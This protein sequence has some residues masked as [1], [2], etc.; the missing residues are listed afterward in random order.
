MNYETIA[1]VFTFLYEQDKIRYNWISSIPDDIGDV[2][3]DNDYVNS[4]YKVNSLLLEQLFVN[5]S[6]IFEDINYFL[7]ECYSGGRIL[8]KDKEYVF[9]VDTLLEEV[10]I[11][12]KE[13]YFSEEV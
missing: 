9:D 10:L 6:A 11:Y 5:D 7:Y 8:A 1:N 2:F 13:V 3:Y 12:F 4:L